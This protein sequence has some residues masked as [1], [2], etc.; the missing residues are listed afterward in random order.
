[1]RCYDDCRWGEAFLKISFGTKEFFGY[2]RE[3]IDVFFLMVTS[4]V[5]G[6]KK[7]RREIIPTL[8]S[9]VNQLEE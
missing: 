3:S 5:F 7:N 2:E 1:M 9:L 8:F 4:N 6:C